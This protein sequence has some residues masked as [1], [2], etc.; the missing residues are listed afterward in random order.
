[1]QS[2]EHA[3]EHYARYLRTERQASPHT[4]Q[5]YLRDIQKLIAALP[6]PTSV[7][8]INAN[9]IRQCM[10]S[11]HQQ[12]L[13]PRSLQRWLS[14]IRRLFDFL[15]RQKS[16]KLNPCEGIRPPKSQKAL[17]KTLD[18]DAVNQLLKPPSPSFLSV[19]DLAMAE[20]F[21]SSGLRL[22]ELINLNEQDMDLSVATLRVTGKGNKTRQLPIGRAAI[23]AIKS[24]LQWR[25]RYRLAEERAVFISQQGRRIGQRTVQQRLKKLGIDRELEQGL[26]PHM[27]RHSFASHLLESSGDL[28]AVQE[29]LGH[30]NIS[31]TQIYTHLDFQHLAKV[32]DQAHPR[33]QKK[34]E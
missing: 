29:L 19:R 11:L 16:L 17:P 7:N 20:L 14:A 23:D 2:L 4:Q 21:Y 32:Y 31:T 12:G 27:L 30:A 15:I 33:A 5:S 26:H 34:E 10:A 18:V 13:S 22:S 3:R 1:M 9:T 6:E 24:W 28:R 8:D 25:E